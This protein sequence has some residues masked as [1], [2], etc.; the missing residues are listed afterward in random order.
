MFPSNNLG[1]LIDLSKDLSK[2]AIIDTS[3][4]Y[5]YSF[6]LVHDLANA[7]ANGLQAKGYQPQDR[8]AILAENSIDFVTTYLGILKL[9]AVVVLVNVKLPQSQIND[10]LIDSN[11][12]LIFAD[13]IIET[14]IPVIN[15]KTDFKDFL[16]NED[17]TSHPVNDEVAIILYTSGSTGAFKG[18]AITHKNH[19]WILDQKAKWVY[20]SQLRKLVAAPMYHMNGLSNVEMTL[21]GYSTTILM[22]KFEPKAFVS[23]IQQYRVNYISS[24][25]SMIASAINETELLATLDVSSLKMIAMGSAPVSQALFEKIKLNFPNVIVRNGYGTT[26][27]GPGLFGPNHPDSLPIPDLSVGYPM[28]GL[29]CRL[30]DGILEI[31]S[32]AMMANYTNATN[33]QLTDDGFFITNDFFE[34]DEHGFYFFRGRADDM[35]KSGGNTIFPA[36]IELALESHPLIMTAAVV[37]IEDDI[38]GIK[39][40]AF[41]VLKKDAITSSQTSGELKQFVATKFPL[42]HCPR[43]IWFLEEMPVN[44]VN[45]LDKTKLSSMAKK[46]LYKA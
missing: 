32:P 12:K 26:E 30:V 35:F 46:L 45:K 44:G 16:I 17:F 31:K 5:R 8:I 9:G 15:F 42:S 18:V 40:Y 1:D 33:T 38:K 34:V 25:P 11:V 36:Q 23:S 4:N 20:A 13:T 3:T 27:L 24:V 43:E 39:P 41:V 6:K 21:S 37:G 19:K 22:P 10:I 29:E 28:A 7:V 14:T 2:T